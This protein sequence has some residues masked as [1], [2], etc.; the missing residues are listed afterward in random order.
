METPNGL[1]PW[2]CSLIFNTSQ[3][4]NYKTQTHLAVHTFPHL[5]V[6][7][8]NS[9]LLEA[10][11]SE[12]ICWVMVMKIGPFKKWNEACQFFNSWSCKTRGKLR[13]LER[14]VELFE[15]FQEQFQL[16]MWA[17]YNHQAECIQKFA[18]DPRVVSL[19]YIP[20]TPMEKALHSMNQMRET[21]LC[22]TEV[23]KY[24]AR[25]KKKQKR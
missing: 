25:K 3:L 22:G 7:W 23:Q 24:D 12:G 9:R 18:N 21:Y 10:H 20:K 14:G 6:D 13:R 15:Q 1:G 4:K 16:K 11:R 2:F 19:K 5:Y 8:L 17:E